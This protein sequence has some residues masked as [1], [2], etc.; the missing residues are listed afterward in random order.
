MVE[1]VAEAKIRLLI[2]VIG[3]W[4]A[5]LPGSGTRR[6]RHRSG[7]QASSVRIARV[8]LARLKGIRVLFE[9]DLHQLAQFV[10]RAYD[11]EQAGTT[12]VARPTLHGLAGIYAAALHV[13]RE[14]VEQVMKAHG[15]PLGATVEFDDQAVRDPAAIHAWPRSGR[16]DRTSS[17]P[18]TRGRT[19]GR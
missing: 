19:P 8:H 12:S 14:A 11:A 4:R 18:I 10:L 6:R 1:A 17:G 3:A 7:R 5:S 16:V 2:M 15:L 9:G 13:D